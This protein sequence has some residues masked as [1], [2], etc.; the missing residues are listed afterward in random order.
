MGSRQ[1][2]ETIVAHLEYKDGRCF[3]ITTDH[4][5]V[6][7]R[8]NDPNNIGNVIAFRC[9]SDDL[10]I[11]IG[12]VNVSEQH[13]R[14][15]SLQ[16]DPDA[17]EGAGSNSLV[18]CEDLQ[19]TN[20]TWLVSKARQV[21]VGRAGSSHSARLL[22]DGDIIRIKPDY[23]F[24]FRQEIQREMDLN[25]LQ[26]AETQ[27]RVGHSSKMKADT[28]SNSSRTSRLGEECSAKECQG[29]FISQHLMAHKLPARLPT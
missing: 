24:V 12:C 5:I 6:L 9:D 7:G 17:E 11:L 13:A 23:E 14:I 27:V 18:Y 15:Y 19:S 16:Y 1:Q 26:I 2:I 21:L 8:S 20:G 22:N 10:D 29:P 4:H 25:E 3:A 28:S